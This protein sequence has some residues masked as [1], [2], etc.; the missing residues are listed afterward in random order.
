MKGLL[1]SHTLHI[2]NSTLARAAIFS[3]SYPSPDIYLV[4]K[5]IQLHLHLPTPPNGEDFFEFFL[6]HRGFDYED[7]NS[8]GGFSYSDNDTVENIDDDDV[9]PHD[10]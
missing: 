3:I 4:I 2:D 5:V 7:S 9:S 8:M 10:R 6:R 1:R